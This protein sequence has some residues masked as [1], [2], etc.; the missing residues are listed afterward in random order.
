MPDEIREV[1]RFRARSDD[2]EEFTI[3]VLQKF[4]DAKTM[5]HPGAEP[6]PSRLK[7]LQTL[8]G[9]RVNFIDETTF[10]IVSLELRVHRIQ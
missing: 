3:I 5:T 1:D 8:E 7:T 2:G 4:L 9:G 6:V 10:E